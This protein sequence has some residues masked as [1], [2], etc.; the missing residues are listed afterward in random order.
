MGQG[1]AELGVDGMAL[2]RTG[3]SKR[4]GAALNPDLLSQ[5][6]RT[7]RALRLEHDPRPELCGLKRGRGFF[8]C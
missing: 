7:T 4:R 6:T 5:A 2:G 3:E 8:N 1:R